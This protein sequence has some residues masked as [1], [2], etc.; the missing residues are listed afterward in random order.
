MSASS[1][2]EPTVLD[3]LSDVL[4]ET[5]DGLYA[6]PVLAAHGWDS[7]ASLEA[8]AQLEDR[9]QITLDLRSFHAAH[10]VPDMVALVTDAVAGKAR[11]P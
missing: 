6:E 11:I 8:L 4:R 10:T 1:S 9:L 5:P 2:V 7:I 3:I